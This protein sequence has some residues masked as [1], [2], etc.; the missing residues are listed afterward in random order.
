MDVNKLFSNHRS[1]RL[2]SPLFLSSRTHFLGCNHSLKPPTSSSSSSASSLRSRN[3][4]NKLGLLRLHSPRFVFKAA[5]N[6]QLIVVV[7]VVTLSAVSWI[8]FT[9]NNKKKKNLNQVNILY[10]LPQFGAA[11]LCPVS[12]LLF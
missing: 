7:V 3:K 11:F 8:H 6:S 2:T 5:L 1:L 10:T 9:L 12:I 4:R